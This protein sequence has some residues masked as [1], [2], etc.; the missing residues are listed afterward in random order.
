MMWIVG[1]AITLYLV[2]LAILWSQQERLIYPA[3]QTVGPTTGGF[4]EISYP[5]DDGLA[6][7]AGYREAEAGKPTIVY[8]HGNGADW[9]SSVVATDRLVPAGYGVLAA[10][11]RGYRGNPGAPSEEGLY[12]DGRAAIAFLARRGISADD[13][14]II[15][16]S[17]GSGVATHLAAE[18]GP[19]AL[20]LIS[21][22]ASMRQLVAEKIRW[23]PTS[24][25]LRHRYENIEKI[26]AVEAPV[27]L[28]HGDADR[29]IPHA[30][31]RQLAQVRRDAK[32]VI[33]P[34]KGHDLAWHDEAEE[35][36]L[37]FLQT[38]PSESV[39]E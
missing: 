17:I 14:V 6:I 10:E 35:A 32:L 23:F 13:I 18:I 11:Y 27:L 36:V 9:V 28:L 39:T 21:P 22:F 26:G 16:N 5:T 19:R 29:V 33:Y 24:T 34:G 25:F 3:P 7:S 38:I 12:L 30:H 8:F 4:E 2:L 20:V 1:L 37:S 15:G 31:T